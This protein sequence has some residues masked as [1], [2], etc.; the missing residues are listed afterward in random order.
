MID[1]A[2]RDQLADA[3]DRHLRGEIAYERIWDVAFGLLGESE[4]KA[5]DFIANELNTTL[6]KKDVAFLRRSQTFLKSEQEYGWPRII[7]HLP[8]HY[9]TVSLWLTIAGVFSSFVLLRFGGWPKSFVIIATFAVLIFI[10]LTRSLLVRRQIQ[11]QIWRHREQG[12]EFE[13]WPFT[14]FSDSASRDELVGHGAAEPKS[15]G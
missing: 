13:A 15:V 3:I 9:T 10:W 11:A 12:R 4:D 14:A 5:I 7:I 6:P 8:E 1:R 2:A